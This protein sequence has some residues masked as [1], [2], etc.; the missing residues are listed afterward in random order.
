MQRPLI[1]KTNV[2]DIFIKMVVKEIEERFSQGK[3]LSQDDINY[4]H[5]SLTRSNL[6]KEKRGLCVEFFNLKCEKVGGFVA[7]HSIKI[8]Q[9]DK[10]NSPTQKYRL[11]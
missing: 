3:V 5:Q 9:S 10:P 6:V 7:S 8:T 4:Q 1:D 11:V 2:D